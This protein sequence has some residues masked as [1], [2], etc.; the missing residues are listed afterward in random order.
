V[1]NPGKVELIL[2]GV[3]SGDYLGEDDIVRFDDAYGRSG[4]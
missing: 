1:A 2:I 4:T 3:Q